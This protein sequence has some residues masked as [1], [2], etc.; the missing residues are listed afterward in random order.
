MSIAGVA[1]RGVVAR[2]DHDDHEV[3]LGAE[4]AFPPRRGGAAERVDGGRER[5]PGPQ[6]G[7]A[8]I[9]R[10][11]RAYRRRSPRSWST[12]SHHSARRNCSPAATP[13]AAPRVLWSQRPDRTNPTWSDAGRPFG[14]MFSSARAMSANPAAQR[15]RVRRHR[16]RVIDDEQHVDVAV[17]RRLEGL[18][19][20]RLR[21][22]APVLARAGQRPVAARRQRGHREKPARHAPG[23]RHPSTNERA[24]RAPRDGRGRPAPAASIVNGVGARRNAIVGSLSGGRRRGSRRHDRGRRRTRGRIRGRRRGRCGRCRWAGGPDRRTSRAPRRARGGGFGIG[25]VKK[26]GGR[27]FGVGGGGGGGCRLRLMGREG[28]GTPSVSATQNPIAAPTP[29]AYAAR[30]PGQRG[31]SATR[32]ALIGCAPCCSSN[33]TAAVSRWPPWQGC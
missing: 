32:R 30:R 29:P 33:F 2:G 20:R 12:V 23:S 16:G 19:P 4:E 27:V 13:Q 15:A 18:P 11:T 7:G 21:A 9:A 5:L 6:S 14:G 17:D 8:E 10:G 28:A 26:L 22:A 24:S 25:V 31:Q 3:G 1:P